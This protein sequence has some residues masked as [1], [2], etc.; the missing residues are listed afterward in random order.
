MAIWKIRAKRKFNNGTVVFE[1]GMEIDFVFNSNSTS[2]S[3]VYSN[4]KD[5]QSI[6]E[7]FIS[8]YGLKCSLEKFEQQVNNANFD[9]VLI[10]K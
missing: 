1:P 6:S 8:K 9:F 5:R 2:P 10:S 3:S 7:Q 4:K